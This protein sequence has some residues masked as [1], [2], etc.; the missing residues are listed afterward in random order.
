[1]VNS[2]NDLVFA[3]MYIR[4]KILTLFFACPDPSNFSVTLTQT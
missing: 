1:M 2:E 4:I 3:N